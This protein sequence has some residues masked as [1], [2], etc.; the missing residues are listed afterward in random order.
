[1]LCRFSRKVWNY[2]YVCRRLLSVRDIGRILSVVVKT[3]LCKQIWC[4]RRQAIPW[5]AFVLITNIDH[6]FQLEV[7]DKKR[8]YY[9]QGLWFM[10]SHNKTYD[11]ENKVRKM[12]KRQKDLKIPTELIPNVLYV[13]HL[14]KWICKRGGM[15]R[16]VIITTL[17]AAIKICVFYFLNWRLEQ[18]HLLSSNLLLNNLRNRIF[19]CGSIAK[20][21]ACRE[22]QYIAWQ[23]RNGIRADRQKNIYGKDSG[24]V[25]YCNKQ[26]N[27]IDSFRKQK[28][29]VTHF[30]ELHRFP[31]IKNS[32]S[33][34]G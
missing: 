10:A 15:R 12:V 16:Q 11:N 17:F 1:M 3:H 9:T 20:I 32:L 8:L 29:G 7:F 13:A 18:T 23:G 14:W 24:D 26:R 28:N 5:S 19:F 30:V 2:R 34:V 6:Q 31:Y 25:V 4:F 33:S 21:W 27:C 22:K